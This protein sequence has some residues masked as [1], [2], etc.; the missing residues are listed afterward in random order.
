MIKTIFNEKR[1]GHLIIAGAL[2]AALAILVVMMFTPPAHASTTP[3]RLT[4]L[5]WA[6]NQAG[7]WYCYGGTG[8]GC[9][10]C[11]GL[12]MKAWHHAGVWLPR[13]TYEMIGSW[14]TVRISAANRRRGDLAFYGTGH[15]ELV[16]RRG[17]FGALEPGTRVGWHHP[18]GWWH[19][20]M[21]F[22]IR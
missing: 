21:Y 6:E 12:A 7:K 10:D 13:T 4:A 18:S 8:P 5:R 19:P 16:T 14:H 22:R 20:T 15:V 9:F 11:S 3:R 17:T 1:A 2:I